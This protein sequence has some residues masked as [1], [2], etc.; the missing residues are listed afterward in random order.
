MIHWPESLP[1]PNVDWS[2]RVSTAVARTKMESGR[3]RQRRRFTRDFRNMPVSWK[4]SD[5]EFGYFQSIYYHALDSG[6][7]FFTVTLPMGDGMKSYTARFVADSYEAKY[8][9]VMYWNIT[10][11][12]DM[13]EETAPWSASDIDALMAAEFDVDAF[14]GTVD[15]LHEYIH[16]TLPTLMPA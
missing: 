8:D 11:Q 3:F 2:I 10:A 13:E 9:N 16:V 6:T 15:E 1:K 4:L 7:D 12:L 5:A 14:E